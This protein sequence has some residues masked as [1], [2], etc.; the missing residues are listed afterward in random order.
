MDYGVAMH[1]FMQHA[2]YSVCATEQGVCDEIKRLA[3]ARLLTGDQAEMIS[4][5]QIVKFFS[6]ELGNALIEKNNVIREFKFS[7]LVDADMYYSDVVNEQILLK[8]VIDCASIDEDGICVIDF[9][10]DY[11]TQ[12]TIHNVAERYRHQVEAY[13]LALQRIYGLPVK[14]AYLYFFSIGEFLKI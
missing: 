6:T 2:K 3:D 11:V 4:P 5:A 10:T 9:K 8:G 13:K 1:C 12:D 7:V 14:E